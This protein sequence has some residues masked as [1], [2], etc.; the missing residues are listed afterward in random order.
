MR[1]IAD[2]VKHH[3]AGA[4][5]KLFSATA[6][7]NATD[8]G[9]GLKYFLPVFPSG[10]LTSEIEDSGL[11][12]AEQNQDGYTEELYAFYEVSAGGKKNMTSISPTFH[13]ARRTRKVLGSM[14]KGTSPTPQYQDQ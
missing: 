5:E 12:S 2:D 8:L 9:G 7:K 10:K 3:D 14:P 6:R 1:H 13:P 4:L 11:G